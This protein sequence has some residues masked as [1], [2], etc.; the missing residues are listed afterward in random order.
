MLSFTFV[1]KVCYNN[2]KQ[3]VAPI[4]HKILDRKYNSCNNLRYTPIPHLVWFGGLWDMFIY[5]AMFAYFFVWFG[6]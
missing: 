2:Y 5:S 4:W 1:H 3:L 6:F